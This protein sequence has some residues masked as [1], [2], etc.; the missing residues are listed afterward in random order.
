[1]VDLV[2]AMTDENPA[3]RPTIENVISKFSCIRDSLSRFKLRTLITSKKDPSL[4]TAYR[5]ARQAVRTL[6]YIILRRSAIPYV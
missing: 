1:M 4:F 3:N 5:Y 2:D 6:Q